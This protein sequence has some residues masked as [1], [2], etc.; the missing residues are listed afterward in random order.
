MLSKKVLIISFLAS[1]LA[2]NTNASA[3]DQEFD[4]KKWETIAKTREA[5]FNRFNTIFNESMGAL[6][7]TL[8][9]HNVDTGALVLDRHQK[10][11]AGKIQ[12]DVKHV[13][14]GQQ[15]HVTSLAGCYVSLHDLL[16]SELAKCSAPLCLGELLYKHTQSISQ[17]FEGTNLSI[18]T[19]LSPRQTN[20]DIILEIKHRAVP[21][22]LWVDFS[23]PGL[24]ALSYQPSSLPSLDTQP[25]SQTSVSKSE[26]SE[27][28]TA[29]TNNLSRWVARLEALQGLS[30]GEFEK[31]TH[32]R[33][34][35]C[36]P[37]SKAFQDIEKAILSF[38]AAVIGVDIA[39]DLQT[40]FNSHP[41]A[42]DNLASPDLKQ[43]NKDKEELFFD[44]LI[45]ATI[46]AFEQASIC[47]ELGVVIKRGN[48]VFEDGVNA[49]VLSQSIK[50]LKAKISSLEQNNETPD[51]KLD[52]IRARS[53]LVN[54]ETQL[55]AANSAIEYQNSFHTDYNSVKALK[56]LAAL[57]NEAMRLEVTVHRN[58]GDYGD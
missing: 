16:D 32:W 6:E 12:I 49:L 19:K 28:E 44:E 40:S 43:E 51:I 26:T 50:G 30:P 9:Y 13:P 42:A 29:T 55:E 1:F 54:L 15:T 2:F 23:V 20:D 31:L 7:D 41:T 48:I 22:D 35:E 27:E 11:N 46:A 37:V 14:E 36:K 57:F 24:R 39:A 5:A 33:E 47:P 38:H 34:T 53:E 4:F 25:D 3:Y 56:E 10:Q 58:H 17:A 18:T 52:I 8:K 45:S 21:H